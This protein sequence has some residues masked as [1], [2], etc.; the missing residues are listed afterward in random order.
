MRKKADRRKKRLQEQPAEAHVADTDHYRRKHVQ[1]A[2]IYGK[3]PKE[4]RKEKAIQD[5]LKKY[6][7]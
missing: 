5:R 7:K 4:V 1:N 2:A 6:R 3:R